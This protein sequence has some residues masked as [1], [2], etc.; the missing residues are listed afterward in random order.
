LEALTPEQNSNVNFLKATSSVS[1]IDTPTF[2]A[3]EVIKNRTIDEAIKHITN[4]QYESAIKKIIDLHI[5][6]IRCET[7]PGGTLF[8]IVL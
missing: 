8:E 2:D 3:T 1:E 4:S 6:R 7:G 5:G